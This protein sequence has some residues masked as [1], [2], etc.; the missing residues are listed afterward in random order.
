VDIFIIEAAGLQV[1]LKVMLKNS[2]KLKL[3]QQILLINI[4]WMHLQ[5][6]KETRILRVFKTF[7]MDTEKS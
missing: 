3:R 6:L 1:E 5:S 2:L 4:F 7:R